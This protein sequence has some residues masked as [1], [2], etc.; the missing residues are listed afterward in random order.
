MLV[1]KRFM[2]KYF[3]FTKHANIFVIQSCS[4]KKN[5]RIFNFKQLKLKESDNN[6]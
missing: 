3:K 1:I 5:M 6:L 2:I 4:F